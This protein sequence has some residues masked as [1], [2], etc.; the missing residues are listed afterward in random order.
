MNVFNNSGL[1]R[2]VNRISSRNVSQI[3]LRIRIFLLDSEVP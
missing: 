3:K 2:N 1:N